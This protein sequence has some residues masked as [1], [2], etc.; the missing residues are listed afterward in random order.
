MSKTKQTFDSFNV[1]AENR[2]AYHVAM[3]AVERPGLYNP[4]VIYG[5]I[6]CYRHSGKNSAKCDNMF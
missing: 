1:L 5:P 6:I 2:F 4:I 3:A